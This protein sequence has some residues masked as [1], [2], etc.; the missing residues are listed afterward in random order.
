MIVC[1]SI[2]FHCELEGIG[3]PKLRFELMLDSEFPNQ[4]TS[5]KT[6]SGFIVCFSQS[7]FMLTKHS[8]L[9]D[10]SFKSLRCSSHSNKN[11]HSLSQ[12]QIT[13]KWTILIFSEFSTDVFQDL[14]NYYAHHPSPII[15]SEEITQYF[16]SSYSNQNQS[17]LLHLFIAIIKRNLSDS[18]ISSFIAANF[19]QL[20]YDYL[21]YGDSF[22]ILAYLMNYSSDI[23]LWI[24]TPEI[25]IFYRIT[26]FLKTGGYLIIPGLFLL[27]WAPH[28][29]NADL[30]I[31]LEYLAELILS[32][33]DPDLLKAYLSVGRQWVT[34]S[35]TFNQG[36]IANGLIF[37]CPAGSDPLF[38]NE[39]RI[40]F[41]NFS[42]QFNQVR[43]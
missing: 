25:N 31:A 10:F 38:D 4:F 13:E 11:F 37:T 23:R 28:V 7:F 41:I 34:F 40:Q 30:T 9:L 2:L 32:E 16:I 27:Y 42:I 12:S 15:N 5:S 8:Q 33:T 14:L 6:D 29:V 20:I 1:V 39:E 19:H 36:L 18:L 35:L 3:S 26:Q 43:E 24:C 17:Q 21:P 22:H